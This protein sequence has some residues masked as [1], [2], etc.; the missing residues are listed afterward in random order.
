M[1]SISNRRVGKIRTY[2]CCIVNVILP[3]YFFY[4]VYSIYENRLANLKNVS[5]YYSIIQHK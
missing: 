3:K 2:Y 5:K 1:K 4:L